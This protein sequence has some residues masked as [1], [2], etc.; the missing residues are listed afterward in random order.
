MLATYLIRHADIPGA[1][2]GILQKR[3]GEVGR[4]GGGVGKA[5]ELWFLET[6]LY[7]V[8]MSIAYGAVC[9]YGSCKIMKFCLKK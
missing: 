4:L 9:G 8:F 5:I 3:N 6:W 7:T 2:E 1:G